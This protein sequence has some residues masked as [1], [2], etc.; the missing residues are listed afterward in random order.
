MVQSTT[1]NRDSFSLEGSTL[2][3]PSGEMAF[4]C[5]M[6]LSPCSSTAAS[7]SSALTFKHIV[8]QYSFGVKRSMNSCIHGF[9]MLFPDAC[10]NERRRVLKVKAATGTEQKLARGCGKRAVD[11]ETAWAL[12]LRFVP[13]ANREQ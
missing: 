3:E 13:F 7:C 2:R 6:N 9:A 4:G 11:T 5:L 8:C 10:C 1:M 12:C